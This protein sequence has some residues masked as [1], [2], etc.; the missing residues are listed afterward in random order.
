MYVCFASL[1]FPIDSLSC[2][3]FQH[4]SWANQFIRA[5]ACSRK[6]NVCCHADSHATHSHLNILLLLLMMMLLLL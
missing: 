6:L 4:Q 2:C 3:S 1:G 5:C